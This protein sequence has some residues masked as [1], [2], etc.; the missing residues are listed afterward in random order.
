MCKFYN[1]RDPGYVGVL[2]PLKR[3]VTLI[4]RPEKEDGRHGGLIQHAYISGINQ[5]GLQ[6]GNMNS[7]G[8][9]SIFGNQTPIFGG[10]QNFGTQNY[11]SR[12]EEDGKR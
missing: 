5:G 3:W 12:Q 10:P 1:A 2:G 7:F 9:G 4:A 8:R 11:G 6:I